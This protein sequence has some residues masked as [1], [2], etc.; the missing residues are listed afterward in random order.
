MGQTGVGVLIGYLAGNQESVNIYK[1]SIG[2]EINK[3]WIDEHSLHFQLS[4][5]TKFLLSD[6]GQSCCE[7]R[8]MSTDDDLSYYNN[9]IL[10]D[11]ELKNCTS[12]E[13]DWDEHEI[14]FVDVTTS[15]GTFTL[16]N[17]NIHNGY[18]GGFLIE[19]HNET[20]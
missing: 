1:N 13:N 11:I 19:L 16:A 2:K 20:D 5:G 9:S 3:V 12:E 4:D 14:Q 8:Y 17:H 6:E 7:T 18:Y 10:I 15:K